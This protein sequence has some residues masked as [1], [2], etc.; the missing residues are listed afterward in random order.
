MASARNHTATHLLQAALRQVLGKH[1]EQSGSYVTPNS[2]RFDF[3]HFAARTT[4]ELLKVERIVNEQIMKNLTVVTDCM[5]IDEAKKLGA[6]ALFGEKYGDVVRVVRAGD[7]STELCGG[8]H[9]SATGE[10]GLFKILSESGVAAGV[11]RI[12][13]ITGFN[14][15]DYLMSRDELINNISIT[16]KS[17]EDNIVK[18]ITSLQNEIKDTKKRLEQAQMNNQGASIE[19]LIKNSDNVNGVHVI[20]GIL[21]N[22]GYECFK[23][24]LR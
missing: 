1:V 9:V 20:T 7:F 22:A 13:A 5:A 12:E 14:T 17:N 23:T 16:L 4:E 10:I 6:M 19:D 8:T 18:K 15:Y 3:S 21:D 2:L 11:R 24:K